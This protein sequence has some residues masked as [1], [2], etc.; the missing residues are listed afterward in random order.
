VD[1][2][3]RIRLAGWKA[4]YTP[5]AVAYHG[6]GSGDSMAKNFA[7]IIE[8][9]RKINPRAKYYSFL[10]QRL[11]QIKDDSPS[12]LFTKHFFPFIIKEIG[13][14]GY[15]AIFER[16]TLRLMKDFRRLVPVFIKKRKLV[17]ER[18]K[19]TDAEMA[20]WFV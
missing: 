8:E 13:A 2:G 12:L 6:R 4:V 19:I 17:K 3:W 20:K 7:K 14:W 5:T 10:H 18:T 1:L 16:F 11:M 9:R 15:M